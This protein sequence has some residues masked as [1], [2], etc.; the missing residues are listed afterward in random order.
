MKTIL[1]TGIGGDIGLGI[2]RILKMA[3]VAERIIGCDIHNDHP[4]ELVFDYCEIVKK[5]S[6][7][8]YF[9]SMEQVIKR[10]GVELIIPTVEPELRF[11]AGEGIFDTLL[12]VP[13][14]MANS[15][16]VNIGFDKLLTAEFLN[17]AGLPFP[18]TIPVKVGP[19]P[20]VPCIIKDRF[21][22]GS[23][24]VNLVEDEQV[25]LYQNS[26]PDHIWQEY[27]AADDEEYTCGLYRSA[28]NEIR[29]IVFRRRLKGGVTE[30]GEVVNNDNISRLLVDVATYLEL[31]GSINVQLR[32]S[33]R[34][35]VIFEI[36][37]R[38][39]STVVFRHLLGF[40]DLI[41]SLQEKSG[42]RI[43]KYTPP[44][45]GARIYRGSFEYII[46]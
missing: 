31:R 29:H 41:W 33:E 16:A 9:K 27:L 18:W 30:A 11:F 38:F 34:G 28:C 5:V 42:V 35:P 36:N 25:S 1:V 37:P 19:P 26:R 46:N 43:S 10:H 23:K 8:E 3:R 21:G 39:S 6:D 4:G 12:G 40:Q 7:P 17:A 15:K 32:M 24:D 13:I 20:F 2:G 44:S 14:I 45:D 22:A